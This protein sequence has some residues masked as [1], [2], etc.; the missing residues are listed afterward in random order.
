MAEALEEV[1]A[2]APTP[3]SGS[4]P[5]TGWRAIQP[6]DLA[7]AIRY[8]RRAGDAALAALAP[9]DAV[10]Y[11]TQALE[12]SSQGADADPSSS[13]TWPPAWARPCAS[14]AIRAFATCCSGPA[15]GPPTLGDTDRLVAAVLANNRGTFSTVSTID[16]EKVA[17]LQAALDRLDTD[18]VRRALLLATLC[19][20][21]P[22]AV[23]SSVGRLWPT[24]RWP[25]PGSRA[26]MPR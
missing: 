2:A 24:R 5:A 7:K 14:P 4:W 23:R 10:R 26:T 20:E 3:G 17:M 13:S 21:L 25:S 12:L 9:A 18:D 1:G 11:Y 19:T 6:T 16:E 15:G 8:S 22:S